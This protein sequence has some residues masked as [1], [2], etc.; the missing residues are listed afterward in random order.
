MNSPQ[1]V[2]GAGPVGTAIARELVAL[3]VD[4]RLASRSGRGPQ[5]TGATRVAVD[6]ADA[7]AV[8]RLADGTAVIYNALNPPQ[9]HKWPVLWPPMA[10]ALLS[11]AERSGAVLATVS[12]LY[13][14]GRPDGPMSASS[15]LHPADVKG[16]VRRQMWLDALAAHEAGR[17][18]VVEVRASDYVGAG[19]DSHTSRAAAALVSGS[20]AR[21]I[22]DLD[23]PHSWTYTGDVARTI[24]AA[25]A[26]DTAHGRAW[27]VP[28]NPP[29]TQREVMAD[30]VRISGLPPVPISPTPTAM[31]RLIGVFQPVMRAVADSSYQFTV[32]F[33]VDDAETRSR[34]GLEPNP[35]DGMLEETLA[36]A[37]AIA[38][39]RAGAR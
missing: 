20:R 4:V 39:P 3:G 11:A 32:P 31:L 23:L 6:A 26:D 24:V 7:D 36:H 17:A 5:I 28:S 25:A 29:R 18:R 8:A 14:Y 10:A 13:A 21:L 38:A 27:I 2:V 1:L 34:F 22:G 15:P 35:W 30:M 12:N 37:R 16:E 33:V 19:A 9:Y